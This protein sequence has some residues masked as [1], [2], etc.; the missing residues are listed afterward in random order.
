MIC[1]VWY[2]ILGILV[3]SSDG[4]AQNLAH[5]VRRERGS[6]KVEVLRTNQSLR[7]QPRS[8]L[9]LSV[10]RGSC[11]ECERTPIVITVADLT[12]ENRSVLDCANSAALS[13][14]ALS[15]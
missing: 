1:G 3:E 14:D 7:A 12:H 11:E 2:R 4:R 9:K 8:E 13:A 10:S 6:R 15:A 5:G